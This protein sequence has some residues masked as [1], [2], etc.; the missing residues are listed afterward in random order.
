ML[1]L[2]VVSAGPLPDS[3]DL[4]L[5]V[6]KP[7]EDGHHLKACIKVSR[8]CKYATPFLEMVLDYPLM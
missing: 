4:V 6:S 8:L 2:L 7:W 3:R 1:Q 5:E